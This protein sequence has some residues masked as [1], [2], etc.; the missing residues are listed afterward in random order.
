M[1]V[2]ISAILSP[3]QEDRTQATLGLYPRLADALDLLD[4]LVS[5]RYPNAVI[6]LIAAHSEAAIPLKMGEKV[7][8]MLAREH[9]GNK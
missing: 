3:E 6:P 9:V 2:G 5:M 7:L 4:L 8:D 1:I